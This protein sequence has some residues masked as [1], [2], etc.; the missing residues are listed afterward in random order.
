LIP[1]RLVNRGGSIV[2]NRLSMALGPKDWERINRCLI[3][4]YRELDS[5]RHPRLVLELLNEL[6]PSDNSGVNQFDLNGKLSV[7]TLPENLA[8]EEQIKAIGRRV[9]QNPLATY[10]VATKDAS[11]RMPT[12]FIPMEDFRKLEL[13]REGYAP[14]GIQYQIAGMLAM[15]DETAHVITL[16]RTHQ[17]FTEHERE[18][19]NTL[20]PHLVTSYIN[21]I[22]CS[23]AQHSASQ[24]K[25]VMETAPGAY[26]CFD[27]HGKL[28]WLQEKAKGWLREFFPGEILHQEFV[29][30]P[31]QHLVT[32]SQ[33]DG[34]D[35]KQLSAAKG[36]ELLVVCL[37]SSPVG[38]LI[39]RL[40]RKRRIP[41]PRFRPLP[42]FSKRKNE[43]LQWMVEGKRNAE[44]ARILCL[45]PR[46]VEKHVAEILA[47]LQVEHRAAAILAAM[48]FCARMNAEF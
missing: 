35:P 37:G 20:H 13:Y 47:E 7:V 24:I 39:M 10:Y 26:G 5:Q 1:F 46:T 27:A 2:K 48:E 9:N 3:R 44:I 12:D 16:H 22:M 41:L 43:V 34:S 11:W 4:L 30:Q 18:I 31:V 42:Q 25:A 21:A 33:H 6:V 14:L 17:G 40:E 15:M 23:R 19:L 32:A 36:E 28:A 45:S 8:T 38:G 29:P